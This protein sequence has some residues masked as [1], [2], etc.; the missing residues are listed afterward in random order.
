MPA[1]AGAGAVVVGAGSVEVVDDVGV[2]GAG[3]EDEAVGIREPIGDALVD[4]DGDGGDDD[5]KVV[6]V[7]PGA[8]STS[9]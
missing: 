7:P 3:D 2:V 1:G 6:G 9:A 8:N 4:G 5:G